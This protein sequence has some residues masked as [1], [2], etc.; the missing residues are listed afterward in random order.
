MWIS[1]ASKQY[2]GS[3]PYEKLAVIATVE[4]SKLV[5]S[6]F[7]LAQGKIVDNTP[8]VLPH[9][10]DCAAAMAPAC[11]YALNNYLNLAV[12]QKANI[13]AFAVLRETN[14]VFTACMWSVTFR[15]NLG[16][17]RWMYILLIVLASTATEVWVENKG[18]EYQ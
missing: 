13:A 8:V 6:L 3:P 4:T 11:L 1:L 14:L 5:A 9:R 7:L 12:L 10:V 2:A 16:K 18:Y 15:A 17:Q